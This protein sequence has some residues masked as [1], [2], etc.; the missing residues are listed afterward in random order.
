MH[1]MAGEK[2]ARLGAN[3]SMS[4]DLVDYQ[5]QLERALSWLREA[6]DPRQLMPPEITPP[7]IKLLAEITLFD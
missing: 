1:Q 2:F 5:A 6:P 7:K 4:L 3:V